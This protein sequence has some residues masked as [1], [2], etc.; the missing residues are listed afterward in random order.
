MDFQ[1]FDFLK[2]LSISSSKSIKSLEIA[3]DAILK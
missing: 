3:S 1:N 2:Y